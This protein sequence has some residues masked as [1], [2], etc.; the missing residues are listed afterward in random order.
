[1]VLDFS[2]LRSS[3]WPLSAILAVALLFITNTAFAADVVLTPASDSYVEGQIFTAEVQVAPSARSVSAVAATILF[4][5]DTLSVV[6]L[7]KNDSAFPLWLTEPLFSNTT[8]TITFSAASQ[9]P[10][11]DPTTLLTITFRATTAGISAVTFENTSVSA[12]ATGSDVLQNTI[13]STYT[14]TASSSSLAMVEAVTTSAD[15]LPLAPDISSP[16]FPDPDAWYM[17]KEGIFSWML[18]P[19]VTAVAAELA[20]SFD[21]V[22]EEVYNPPINEFVILPEDIVEGIQYVSVQYR[23]AIGWGA[24][25]NLPLKIDFTPPEPFVIK[26][27]SLS[28]SSSFPTIVFDANDVM[29]GIDYYEL[30]IGGGK[31]KRINHN[32]GVIAYTLSELT[33]GAYNINVTAYDRA[34]NKAISTTAVAVAAGWAPAVEEV[35]EYVSP[36]LL[37]TKNIIFLALLLLALLQLLYIARLTTQ[38]QNKETLLRKETKEVQDQ[39]EKIFSALRYEIYD[40]INTIT[41]R[42]RL[43]KK[44]K[45]AVEGLQQALEVSE[46]LIEKEIDD[47]KTILQ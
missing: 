42:P 44:E 21:N 43:S 40:Q 41:K 28:S 8:G 14:I 31:S 38:Y 34:G 3:L 26:L 39:M 9:T 29:S 1:M 32:D 30:T 6:N 5:P 2:F 46:A 37:T 19:A 22:P 15:G 25:T 12:A 45:E 7:V 47:V 10:L 11:T 13:G 24:I 35:I 18:D 20:A 16:A 23:N 33:D 17:S 4:D 27:A 36:P